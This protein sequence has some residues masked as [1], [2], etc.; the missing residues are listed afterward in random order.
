MKDSLILGLIMDGYEDYYHINLFKNTN[1]SNNT[2]KIEKMFE[3]LCKGMSEE[4]KLKIMRD[5]DEAR[6]EI[7]TVTSEEYFK[8]GFKLGLIMGVQNFL[9]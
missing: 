7:E 2:A 1:Y 8:K 9:D 4:E 3:E 5:Y 6:N